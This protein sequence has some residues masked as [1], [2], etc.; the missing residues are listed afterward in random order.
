MT[1]DDLLKDPPALHGVA[2][3]PRRYGLNVESLRF[4]E[5]TVRPGDATLE[6]GAGFSTIVFASSAG[7]HTCVTPNPD[8]IS[9]ITAHCQRQGMSLRHVTFERECSEKVLPRLDPTPL[10]VVLLDGSH[11]FPQV[12]IDWF[13]VAERLVV[14]GY[15]IIDDV[16]L[17]TGKV[18]RDFL[19][20]EPGWDLV[21]ML[22]GRT[23]VV[24]KVEGGDVGRDWTRQPYVA[25]RSRRAVIAKARVVAAMLRSGDLAEVGRLPR[26]VITRR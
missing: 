20:A 6:T 19:K 4:I 12:F 2:D 23:A 14:G 11:S 7:A 26:R 15:I 10:N 9:R 13:F 8:Q 21:S 16:H 25:S 24:R 22:G 3:D 5:S 17:W 18:L 1:V